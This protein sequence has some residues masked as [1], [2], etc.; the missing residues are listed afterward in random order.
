MF[1]LIFGMIGVVFVLLLS[2]LI[3][4]V[5][6]SVLVLVIGG[7]HIVAKMIKGEDLLD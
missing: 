5:G 7:I 3:L 4:A 1:D 2:A 6:I